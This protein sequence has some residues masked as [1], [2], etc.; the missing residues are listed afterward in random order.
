LER[1]AGNNIGAIMVDANN[2]IIGW[3]L[4][5]K[6]KNKTFHAETLMI[7]HYLRE[8]NTDRLPDDVKIYTSLEC[9]HMCAGYIADMSHGARVIFAQ[10]DPFFNGDNALKR[11]VNGGSATN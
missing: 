7:Q 3:G 1:A 11:G 6:S 8:N 9:C 10:K 2:K 5:L 4:N